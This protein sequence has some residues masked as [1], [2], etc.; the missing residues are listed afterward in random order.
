MTV[1]SYLGLLADE[2]DRVLGESPPPTDYP[3][4]V[5][6]AWSLSVS[7]LREQAPYALELLQ[8]CAFFGPAPDPA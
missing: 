5:A 8:R 7:R 2:S 4:P 1:N 6:A 3:L